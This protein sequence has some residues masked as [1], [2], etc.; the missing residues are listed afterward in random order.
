MSKK[1]KSRIGLILVVGAFIYISFVF[2]D[3]QKLI[4]VKNA[5]MQSIQNKTE[6]E[7]KLSKDLNEQKDLVNSIEYVEK[8]AR[9]KLGMIK[10]GE[11][12]FVDI[13]R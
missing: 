3:Q 7:K 5:E 10:P 1:K 11:K 6:E 12:I 13:N 4:N 8:I 9:E 2:I